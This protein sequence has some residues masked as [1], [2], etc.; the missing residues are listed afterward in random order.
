MLK[1]LGLVLELGW[2]AECI[3]AKG[4]S[5]QA[6]GPKAS[7]PLKGVG[8]MPRWWPYLGVDS[9]AVGRVDGGKL[10]GVGRE[11][12]QAARSDDEGEDEE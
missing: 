5:T 10:E 7:P 2:N 9:G 4:S 3:L 6:S 8:Q 11:G 1:G 12:L